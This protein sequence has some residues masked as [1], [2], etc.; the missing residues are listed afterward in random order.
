MAPCRR[1]LDRADP[2]SPLHRSFLL[3]LPRPALVPSRVAVGRHFFRLG[4]AI[5]HGFLGLVEVGPRGR[6]LRPSLP[7]VPADQ[8]PFRNRLSGHAGRHC[9]RGT[10]LRHAASALYLPGLCR[11]SLFRVALVAQAVGPAPCPYAVG[12]PAQRFLAGIVRCH[13]GAGGLVLLWRSSSAGG[14]PGA[15][16]RACLF[17]QWQRQRG[18]LL[19]HPVCPG[20]SFALSSGGRVAAPVRAGRHPESPVL[21]LDCRLR[22]VA[23]DR[24]G[25]GHLPAAAPSDTLQCGRRAGHAGFV[26]QKPP[27][28]SAFRHLARLAAGPRA[29][30]GLLLTAP[31]HRAQP[32][33]ARPT[34]CLADRPSGG[35]HGLGRLA[36]GSLSAFPQ[37]LPVPDRPRQFPRGG[38]ESRRGQSHSRQGLQLVQLGWLHRLANRRT[39]AGLYRR[40]CWHG[41]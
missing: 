27:L 24:G 15:G 35:R 14:L 3:H 33:L 32:A 39:L 31:A 6:D 13:D 5:R 19:A 17:R 26:H 16:L 9:R 8:R 18:P 38:D 28:H 37:R 12:E 30:G 23:L 29:G 10:L 7:F 36:A 40:P 41:V 20:H 21:S 11:D 1:S 2:D 34:P 25:L 22:G 4:Q